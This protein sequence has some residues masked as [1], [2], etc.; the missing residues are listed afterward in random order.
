MQFMRNYLLELSGKKKAIEDE[1]EQVSQLIKTNMAEIYNETEQAQFNFGSK[2]KELEELNDAISVVSLKLFKTS[3]KLKETEESLDICIKDTESFIENKTN[4]LE[5]MFE[6]EKELSG[7][8]EKRE[9]ELPDIK[10]DSEQF[11]KYVH[12]L[13]SVGSEIVSL[14]GNTDDSQ[15]LYINANGKIRPPL[16][17]IEDREL[18]VYIQ[19][20]EVKLADGTIK[21]IKKDLNETDLSETSQA[22]KELDDLNIQMS[23]SEIKHMVEVF[24]NNDYEIESLVVEDADDSECIAFDVS[25]LKDEDGPFIV[26]RGV[27]EKH[28]ITYPLVHI[29]N[30][31]KDLFAAKK[32]ETA[33]RADPD[34][35]TVGEASKE[36]EGFLKSALDAKEIQKVSSKHFFKEINLDIGSFLNMVEQVRNS[37]FKFVMFE[38]TIKTNDGEVEN[39]S[40]DEDCLLIPSEAYIKDNASS[41]TVSKACLKTNTGSLLGLM[42]AL[43]ILD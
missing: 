21:S 5:K 18:S 30:Q 7:F 3:Q 37:D 33:M 42:E 1:I 35:I 38:A 2:T 23:L 31:F 12:H 19:E 20:G 40:V 15:A 32:F 28:G 8:Q 14:Y 16:N 11:V 34:V 41:V 43:I 36:Q 4:S 10:L 27:V 24:D 9:P 39:L 13:N 25:D 22:S 6:K 29:Y 26:K 17:L